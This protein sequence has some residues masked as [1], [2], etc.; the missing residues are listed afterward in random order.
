M[1]NAMSTINEFAVTY[2]IRIIGAIAILLVGRIFAG[3]MSRLVRKGCVRANVDATLT[4][5]VTRFIYIGVMAFAVLG[6]LAKFGIQTASFVAVLGAAGFAVGFALQ[7]SLSNFAAGVMLLVFR[8]FKLGDYIDAGGTAGSVK[9]IALFTTTLAT[10]DNVKVIVPN[11]A[12]FG[13]TI[14]NF[15][16][17]DTRR[18]D[19]VIGIGYGSDI[20]K[21]IEVMDGLIKADSRIFADPPHQIAVSELADSSVNFVVRSWVNRD[22]YWGVK[23]D[24]TRSIKESFDAANIEIPFPQRVVHT[25]TAA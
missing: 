19:L 13:G 11:G 12:I 9:E 14:R 22:D 23:F 16:G 7:G 3:L 17:Y 25:V 4:G 6:A 18:V 1:D 5:F 20:Q 2:G 24:L 15:A 10:P 8:P 21:A